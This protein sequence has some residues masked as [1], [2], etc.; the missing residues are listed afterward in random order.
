[1]PDAGGRI[2]KI[3]FLAW[4]CTSSERAQNVAGTLKITYFFKV[5][6]DGILLR[7]GLVYSVDTIQD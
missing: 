5:E 6:Y 4:R 1:M 7:L 3:T 2:A